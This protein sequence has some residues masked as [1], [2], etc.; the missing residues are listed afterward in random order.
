MS[1][2][3]NISI[4]TLDPSYCKTDQ[5][6]NDIYAPRKGLPVLCQVLGQRF[7][8]PPDQVSVLAGASMALSCCFLAAPADRPVLIPHPGFPAY[9]EILRLLGR[10]SCHFDLG[11]DWM[12]SLRDALT[13][14]QPGALL[15]NSPGNPMGNVISDA[16]RE[17]V[18][19]LAVKQNTRVILD[20]TYAGLEF[21]DSGSSGALLGDRPGVIRI[22][23]FSKRFAAPGLRVGYVIADRETA[24][25]IADINW[26]LAMSPGGSNQITAAELMINELQSPIR[27]ATIA[28]SLQASCDVAMAALARHGFTAARPQGGP[29]LWL[30]LTEAQGTGF[31]LA[32][33]C[34]KQAGILV[35][36]GEAFGQEGPPAIRCC[37]ALPPDQVDPVFDR[38]GTALASYGAI[39]GR[40]GNLGAHVL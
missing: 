12:K 19:E 21:Q 5:S 22:G 7:G 8:V 26:V 9:T 25:R 31:D 32:V 17:Q 39:A 36:P 18:I 16:E 28:R 24:D 4:G 15:L 40:G 10:E 27:A 29:L 30:S 13:R 1:N 33:H 11:H 20:E 35:S 6:I 37:F 3:V 23:S 2:L 14:H 34:Q 38:L